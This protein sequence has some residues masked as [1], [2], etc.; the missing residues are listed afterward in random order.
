MTLACLFQFGDWIYPAA[1]PALLDEGR[2]LAAA[3]RGLGGEVLM[4]VPGGRREEPPYSLDEFKRMAETMNHVGAAAREAGVTAAETRLEIEIL[5][6]RLDPRCVGFAPDTGQIAKGGADPL[7][8]VDRWADRVRH[9]HLKDLA[10][11]WAASR[12]AG[13]PLRGPEGYAELGQGII[14]FRP[15]LPILERVGYTGWLM[16]GLDEARRPAREAAALS[17]DYLERT[18]GLRPAPAAG[19]GR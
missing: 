6:D 13:A 16:A 8:I 7:P 15:L 14:D 17:K 9:V 18:L 12:R 5:L 10:P 2:R 4:L 11:E 19:A 1:A 3:V